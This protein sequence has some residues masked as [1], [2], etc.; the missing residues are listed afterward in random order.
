MSASDAIRSITSKLR[1]ATKGAL[2]QISEIRRRISETRAGLRQLETA[3]LPRAEIQER[4][5]TTVQQA[6]AVW[7]KDNARNVLTGLGTFNKKATLLAVKHGDELMSW[8][9]FCASDPQAAITRLLA[10]VEQTDYQP[11]PASALRPDLIA[12][13]ALELAALEDAEEKLVDEA[14]A[15]GIV[16]EHRPEVLQRRQ[17][18]HR[19]RELEEQRVADR[20]RRQEALD[21]AHAQQPRPAGHSQ[22]LAGEQASRLR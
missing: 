18:E 3:P 15:V 13:A 17:Q 14:A 8:G 19:Q 5:A 10:V 21:A 2:E 22:Y 16:I 1:S 12:A 20:R 4:A 7:L 11:G 6:G 9:A